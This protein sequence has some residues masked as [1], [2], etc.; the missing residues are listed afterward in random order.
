M[1][2]STLSVECEKHDMIGCTFCSGKESLLLK[3]DLRMIRVDLELEPAA[4]VPRAGRPPQDPGVRLAGE[5]AS[6]YRCG[7]CLEATT[8]IGCKC[9]RDAVFAADMAAAADFLVPHIQGAMLDEAVG[10]VP[11]IKARAFQGIGTAVQRRAMRRME[12]L[13]GQVTDDGIDVRD[14][15]RADWKEQL[16]I[17]PSKARWH[18]PR[19]NE[20]DYLPV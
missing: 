8:G 13:A 20:A 17:D 18:Q 7:I 14:D 2:D 10:L 16:G 1:A 9:S 6:G 15:W 11:A 4:A 3:P 12:H 5:V 19:N